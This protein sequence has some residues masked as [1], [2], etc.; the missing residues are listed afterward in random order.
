MTTEETIDLAERKGRRPYYRRFDQIDPAELRH[1]LEGLRLLGDDPYMRT[2]VLNLSVVDPFL[3][4]IEHEL[5]KKLIAEERTPVPEAVFVTAQSQ[6]WIFAAYELMRT[7]RQR[8]REIIQW[9]EKGILAVK[10]ADLEQDVG[11]PHF[12]RQF[13]A[14]QL[15]A[16]SAHPSVIEQVKEDLRRSHFLF[17]RMEAI[18]VSIAKHEVSGHRKSVAL[19]PG[20]GRINSDCGSLDFELENGSYSMGFISRRDIADEIRALPTT[21]VPSQEKMKEFDAYMRGIMP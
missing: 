14:R 19:R 8:A 10:I 18:R 13:R 17:R 1:A 11:Y 20:Y 21:E 12:G 4:E 16:V 9:A 5:L 6:M 15:K 2:Q 3:M 7:W